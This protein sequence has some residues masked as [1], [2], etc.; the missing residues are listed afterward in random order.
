MS[1][2]RCVQTFFFFL[3]FSSTKHALHL[4]L[5]ITRIWCRRSF[6]FLAR[7]FLLGGMDLQLFWQQRGWLQIPVMRTRL[8]IFFIFGLRRPW[9]KKASAYPVMVQ[10]LQDFRIIWEKGKCILHML[11]FLNKVCLR[12]LSEV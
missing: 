11:F 9:R 5:L 8:L 6:F 7:G 1:K 12:R 4:S 10:H 2:I 3:T